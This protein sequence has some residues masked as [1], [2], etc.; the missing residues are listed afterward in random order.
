MNIPK[1]YVLVPVELTQEMIQAGIDTE[2]VDTGDADFDELQDYRSVYKS[3]LESAPKAP[4]YD[5]AKE[6]EMFESEFRSFPEGI[7]FSKYKGMYLSV[8]GRIYE[9]GQATDMN[10]QWAGWKAC[11][12]SRA[13]SAE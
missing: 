10:N 4:A 11:A 13:R 1:G 6:R 5:E 3:F 8:N 12:K 9:Q 7:Y 2:C